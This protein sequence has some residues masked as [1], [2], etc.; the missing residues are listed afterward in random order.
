MGYKIKSL[1]I[2]N[3]KYI[4][5]GRPLTLSLDGSDMVILG[6]PN[7]YGKSTVFDAIELLITGEIKHFNADL[8]NRGKEN[9]AIL[10][11]N[12]KDDVIIC[13]KFLGAD[14]SFSLR[15]SFD[16]SAGFKSTIEILDEK[17][18][19]ISQ[20]QLY[21]LLGINPSMFNTGTYVSQSESLDFLQQKYSERKNR[22]TGLLDITEIQNKIEKVKEFKKSF[23]IKYEK[24]MNELDS[25]KK[26]SLAKINQLE[27]QMKIASSTDRSTQ[28]QR[29][30]GQE[31]P[32]DMPEL[33][34]TVSFESIV[35]P[36]RKIKSFLIDYPDYTATKFNEQIDILMKVDEKEFIALYFQI[37]IHE[38][39]ENRIEI[40][41]LKKT[42]NYLEKLEAH[43]YV[44]D[45][46]VITFI[47][48][49]EDIALKVKA[50]LQHIS[51][52]QAQLGQNQKAVLDLSKKRQAL[53][54]SF[55]SSVEKGIW[56]NQQCPLCGIESDQLAELF[57]RT[58]H[59][60]G[61]NSDH[62]IENLKRSELD[63]QKIFEN[64][65]IT[66]AKSMLIQNERLLSNYM[67]LNKYDN[68]KITKLQ[69]YLN[70]VTNNSFEFQENSVDF[71][72][73]Q[74]NYEKLL[75]QLSSMK[76]MVERVLDPQVIEQYSYIYDLYYKKKTP[77]HKVENINEKIAYIAEQYTNTYRNALS[78]ENMTYKKA[79]DKYNA[80]KI[81]F[82]KLK[83]SIDDLVKSHESAFKQYQ[84]EIVNSIKIPLFIYS[85]KIIQ[86]YP[87]G[88]S[89]RLI[90]RDNQLVF[91]AGDKECDLFNLLSTGQLNGVILSVLLSIKAV[92]GNSQGLN[93]LLIDDPLQSIDDISACSFADLLVEQFSES[94]IILS[95]HEND[96]AN[97]FEQKC[98]QADLKVTKINMQDVYLKSE[99]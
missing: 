97:L 70:K 37:L 74:M 50:L 39:N 5:S 47:G 26:E 82:D 94:Q 2:S 85:G 65:I 45:D 21:H 71:H 59:I 17:E 16:C 4:T 81:Y 52:L 11:H 22:F 14:R 91:I 20:D 27:E 98:L 8:L 51:D 30:F 90:V 83:V 36:L 68:I 40:E 62:I 92:F 38:I 13:A 93:M 86:N 46:D 34:M 28:Y 41:K 63:V 75:S 89:I 25:E 43:D 42:T 32:F 78:K 72:A 60:L 96:K 56:N 54:T 64:E 31:H 23:S 61:S 66:T 99:Q 87:M 95:T 9:Q 58:E 69:E 7:G 15:R 53:L 33:S 84:S 55:H 10:A 80:F 77:I 19:T 76:K 49:K 48:L 3:F 12:P 88:L 44:L 67:Q 73:F 57:D 79:A 29:L 18:N 35:E 6:G 24:A 1:T